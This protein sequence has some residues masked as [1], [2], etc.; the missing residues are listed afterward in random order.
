[1]SSSR[2]LLVQVVVGVATSALVA[3]AVEWWREQK[4]R[5]PLPQPPAKGLD[6]V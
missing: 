6:T 4:S 2:A 1:V 3:V 5:A